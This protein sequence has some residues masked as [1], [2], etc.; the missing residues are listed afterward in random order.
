MRNRFLFVCVYIYVRVCV[1]NVDMHAKTAANASSE[2]HCLLNDRRT[3]LPSLRADLLFFLL[4][5]AFCAS[6]SLAFIYTYACMV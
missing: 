2:Q 3:T 1:L 5:A 6:R 4:C